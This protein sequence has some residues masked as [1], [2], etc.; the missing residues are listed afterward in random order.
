MSNLRRKK[1]LE[2]LTT[3]VDQR[4]RQD[5]QTMKTFDDSIS[6]HKLKRPLPILTY[7]SSSVK[8]INETTKLS[9]L[10]SYAMMQH[11]LWLSETDNQS[12]TTTVDATS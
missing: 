9:K 6:L 4:K 10:F 1:Q 2:E 5:I 11:P 8:N 12:Q 7:R 3:M